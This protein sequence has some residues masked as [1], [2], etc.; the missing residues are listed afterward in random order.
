MN[1]GVAARGGAMTS[2][3]DSGRG[4][5][6]SVPIITA[7]VHHAPRT[8]CSHPTGGRIG[9]AGYL[10]HLA[11]SDPR[12]GAQGP[13]SPATTDGAYRRIWRAGPTPAADAPSPVVHDACRHP[14]TAQTSYIFPRPLHGV[15]TF[16]AQTDSQMAGLQNCRGRKGARRCN[17]VPDRETGSHC[18]SVARSSEQ[19]GS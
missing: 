1:S 13:A 12:F 10:C 15:S 14:L 17:A 9:G 6:Q 4:P 7:H 16:G 2:C 5:H 11:E 8:P 18:L 19:S 3:W